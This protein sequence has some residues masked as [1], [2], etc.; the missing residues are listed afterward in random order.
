M[1]VTLHVMDAL[2]LAGHEGEARALVAPRY[3][4]ALRHETSRL[5]ALGG[6]LLAREVLGVTDD[7]QVGTHRHG[8][9]YLTGSDVVFNASNDEGMVVLGVLDEGE[10]PLGIDVNEVPYRLREAELR[11]ARR[12][13]RDEE[14]VAI[15][16]GQTYSGRVAFARAWGSLEA[17]LKA[18]GTGFAYDVRHHPEVLDEWTCTVLGLELAGRSFVIVAAARRPVELTLAIHDAL[19]ELSLPQL[20]EHVT[21]SS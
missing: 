8:K 12:Y 1:H 4:S 5:E 7:A 15:G 11:V 18:M 6:G 2:P 9:P 20:P 17:P 19:G 10:G 16:D 14:L 3:H 21:A 13:F